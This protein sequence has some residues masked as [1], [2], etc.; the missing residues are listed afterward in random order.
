M[1]PNPIHGTNRVNATAP[2]INS[3]SILRM[4]RAHPNGSFLFC[5]LRVGKS[6]MRKLCDQNTTNIGESFDWLMTVSSTAQSS[7]VM[8][9]LASGG[10]LTFVND[11]NRRLLL[12]VFL[13]AVRRLMP[14]GNR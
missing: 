10:F 14:S 5:I 2:C 9:A 13:Q 12:C 7:H 6:I 3:R 1:Q 4:R 11:G 8:H